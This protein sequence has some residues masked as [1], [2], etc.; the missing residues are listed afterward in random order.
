[1]FQQLSKSDEVQDYSA[2]HRI[3]WMFI[4]ALAPW[5]GGFYERLIGT[6]KRAL[7]RTLGK[8]LLTT[9]QLQTLLTEIAAVVNSR[10]LVPP[11]SNDDPSVEALSP[12]HFLARRARR[13]LPVLLDDGDD[14]YVPTKRRNAAQ[15]LLVSWRRGQRL[16]NAYWSTWRNEYLAALRERHDAGR[17]RNT[18]PWTPEVGAVVLV[19]DSLPR[20]RWK[21]GRISQL[22]TSQ[23]GQVRSAVVKLPDNKEI[24]RAIRHLYPLETAAEDASD[25]DVNQAQA[26][27]KD[28][29]RS[30]TGRPTKTPA[31]CE[32]PPAPEESDSEGSIEY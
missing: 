29:G 11:S 1:M 16:L 13:G 15:E 25:E 18:S 14:E 28:S 8:Q 31:P 3:N 7:R 23:D 24:T 21:M 5:M 4:T 2:E 12:A 6:V 22:R 17:Q 27:D 30:R 26:D 19:K 9:P 20:Y 10:P 32:A